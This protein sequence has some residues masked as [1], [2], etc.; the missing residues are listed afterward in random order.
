MLEFFKTVGV[1]WFFE[2]C[3]VVVGLKG[4]V[5]I[6]RFI[7]KV[8]HKG[9]LFPRTVTVESGEGLNRLNT[10]KPLVNIHGAQQRLVKAGLIFV[11]DQQKLII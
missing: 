9:L 1:G 2:G 4:L 5:D 7:N 3:N 8:E 6:L 10:V 11:G